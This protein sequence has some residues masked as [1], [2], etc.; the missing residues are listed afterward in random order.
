MEDIPMPSTCK[1]CERDISI[2]EEQ[3][4]RILTNMRP[5]ME[6]VNYEVYEA[7][8]LACSQCE[9]LMSGHTCGISGSIV[10]VRALAAAQNCP[11]YHGS[12]WIGTA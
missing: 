7:R 9:E 2:S 4:T 8:L 3:I 1:G 12:R 5:K 6:C 10:R 11:S